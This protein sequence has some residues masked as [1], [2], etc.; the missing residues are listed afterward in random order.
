VELSERL[1]SGQLV[2]FAETTARRFF[3]HARR[4]RGEEIELAFFDGSSPL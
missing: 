1:K 3:A 2:P 4:V